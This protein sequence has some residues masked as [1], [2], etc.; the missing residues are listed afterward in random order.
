MP[1]P[2]SV[3]MVASEVH[4]F[5]KTGG[6]AEVSASLS[7]ALG[8]LGHTVTLVLPRYRSIAVDGAE[9]LQ[10]RLR[11]GDRLQP[12]A[13]YERRLS[14]R[15]TVVLVDVP[16][17]FDRDGIYG[18]PRATIRTTRCDLRCSAVRRSS[19]RGCASNAR[20]SS[21]RTTGRRAWCRST[22]RWTC[23]RPVRRRRAGR[24]HDP[25]PGVSGRVSLLDAAGH[26]ARLRGARRAGARVLGQYQLP[27]GRHQ[28]Q[29]ADHDRQ[30]ELRHGNPDARARL[31]LRRR[32]A[33]G[34]PAIWPAS[35]TGST[36][37]AGIPRPMRSCRRRSV[38]TI[39][40][41]SA[42][43]NARFSSAVGLPSD[44]VALARPVIGLISRLT[45]QKGFDLIVAAADELMRSTPP[46]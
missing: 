29:R 21:M 9:R 46:G 40:A 42:T 31:R 38:P 35:S 22:R 12:V 44:D 1:A 39:S 34:G 17:L 27:Q 33:R 23:Q 24:L 36:P 5:A 20:R 28:L 6:L 41:E 11:L 15:V 13:F 32:S 37:R 19:I 16:E 8:T 10:T 18:T 3:L 14:D 43:R 25:Q 7:N 26:R 2:L 45:D 30:P 4:P